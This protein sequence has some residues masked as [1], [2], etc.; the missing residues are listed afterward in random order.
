MVIVQP[1]LPL[2]RGIRHVSLV[3]LQAGKRV[4][5]ADLRASLRAA[6]A[7]VLTFPGSRR[8]AYDAHRLLRRALGSCLQTA[9][10]GPLAAE[11]APGAVRVLPGRK[12]LLEFSLHDELP[13]PLAAE[14]MECADAY[15]ELSAVGRAVLQALDAPLAALMEDE[16]VK[17]YDRGCSALCLF[18]YDASAE[19]ALGA[20]EH[21]DMG[22]LT[23]IHAQDAGLELRGPPR[24]G[25]EPT[26][27]ALRS[28]DD[29]ALVVLVGETLAAATGGAF[30]AA[31]HRVVAQ[32]AVRCSVVLRLRGA[33]SAP[34]AGA[35]GGTVAGFE[36]HFRA[37][38]GSVNAGGGPAIH[39]DLT[40]S[41]AAEPR[42]VGGAPDSAADVVFRTPHLA[43]LIAAFLAED[44]ADGGR[45]LALA[46]P[47]CRGMSD[48]AC[49]HAVSLCKQLRVRHPSYIDIPPELS[50]TA[51]SDAHR[52]RR[53]Y[54]SAWR[55]IYVCINIKIKDQDSTEVH[56][57]VY[58]R[59]KFNK[60][61]CAP[62]GSV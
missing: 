44:Q 22:L 58:T 33:P 37:T 48:A 54:R 24:R 45:A 51:L 60:V 32:P 20:A 15:R 52:W 62:G 34:L 36:A 26:W 40:A 9:R 31:T 28:G 8:G 55:K 42:L 25:G 27:H 3:A 12:R 17:R 19:G 5:V 61:R 49:H 47:L 59:T 46:A 29:N 6:G 56:F 18:R 14:E 16:H 13:E 30:A 57:K 53:L 39:I 41:D 11:P 4:A 21:T 50:E 7:A 38:H 35:P 1:A 10:T 23:L 43:G 2:P